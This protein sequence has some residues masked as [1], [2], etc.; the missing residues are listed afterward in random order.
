MQ[1]ELKSEAF[2]EYYKAQN[3][4]KDDEEYETMLAS[5]REPLP[6]R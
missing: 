6:I 4:C 3:I 5:L 2:D 1:K